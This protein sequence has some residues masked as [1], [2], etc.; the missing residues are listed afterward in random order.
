MALRII[1]L[2]VWGGSIHAPLTDY[3]ATAEA[4][5]FCLQ[6]V[7]RSATDTPDWLEY[8]DGDTVLPQRAHLYDEIAALLPGHDGFFFPFARGD[9]FHGET[10]FHTEFGIATFVRKSYPVIGQ[11]ADF[12]HGRFSPD[13][14]GEHPRA[15]NAHCIRLFDYAGGFPVTVAQLHGLRDP[16]G[17][18]DIPARHAQADAL[19]EL[20]ER[21]WPGDERLVV[22]GDFNV[23]PD[24]ITFEKLGRLGLN[25]LVIGRGFIDTRTSLYPKEGRFA[26]YMLVTPEVAVERFEV[27]ERPEVSDHRALLLEFA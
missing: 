11:A 1:S 12:I 4:D 22:C 13:G 17:K 18:S 8:R 24:S 20:I 19:V 3:L 2:N 27:V 25:D 10:T 23:L 16:A 7:V 9:L 6:E 15:R 26:D 14:W 21:V 5:V